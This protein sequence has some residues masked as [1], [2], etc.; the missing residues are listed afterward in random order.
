M[1]L[2]KVI[3]ILTGTCFLAIAIGY[4]VL[5]TG[6][7]SKNIY[8]LSHFGKP[9]LCADGMP[10]ASKA[11]VN[12]IKDSFAFLDSGSINTPSI[13]TIPAGCFRMDTELTLSNRDNIIIRGAGMDKTF[14]DFSQSSGGEGIAINGGS[15]IVIEDLQVSEAA[16]NGIKVTGVDGLILRDLAAVWLEVPRVPNSDGQLRGT[17]A[18]YP[19]SSKNVL[20]EGTWS[21]GSADAG[22]YV[23]Q[24]QNV[25]VRNNVAERNIAG[26]EIENTFNVDVYDNLALGNTGGVLVFDLPGAA[27]GNMNYSNQAAQ[28]GFGANSIQPLLT[29]HSLSTQYAALEHGFSSLNDKPENLANPTT[30][31]LTRNVRV[32]NNEIR[33]NNL[34]NYVRDICKQSERGCGFAGGVHIVPPGTGL[35]ILS[36]RDTEVYNNVIDNHDTLAAALTSYFIAEGNINKYIPYT[37]KTGQEGQAITFGWNPV[38]TGI[39]IHDNQITN[40]GHFPNGDL[41]EEPGIILGYKLMRFGFPHILYDGIGEG[42]IR[43]KEFQQTSNDL[44]N[45]FT[46]LNLF[47][48]DKT[49]EHGVITLSGLEQDTLNRFIEKNDV[50][51]LSNSLNQSLGSYNYLFH[52][53]EQNNLCVKNNGEGV[54]HGSLFDATNPEIDGDNPDLILDRSGLELFQCDGIRQTGGYATIGGTKYGHFEHGDDLIKYSSKH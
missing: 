49:K 30:A 21:Y 46:V 52:W 43:T 12:A 31:N 18:L 10:W 39:Y 24:S 42:L 11:E 3:G 50:T 14:I 28:Q 8:E 35:V 47:N 29:H 7:P 33:D 53:D 45:L 9:T 32:F 6:S 44:N 2:K 25:V 17:Y 48:L 26:I 51:S 54:T 34:G 27:T 16:K 1:G 20:V 22:V 37:E 23:G 40:T 13:L 19:V 5:F 15:N 41:I 38:P 4:G 36:S